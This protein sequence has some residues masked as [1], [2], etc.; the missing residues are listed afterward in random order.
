MC[1]CALVDYG[2]TGRLS[3]EGKYSGVRPA[4]RAWAA[5]LGPAS[6]HVKNPVRPTGRVSHYTRSLFTCTDASSSIL[7]Y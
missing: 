3:G 4:P 1:T 5:G 6:M 7:E 2:Q